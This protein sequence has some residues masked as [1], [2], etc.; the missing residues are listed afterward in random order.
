MKKEKGETNKETNK[1]TFILRGEN[2]T[3]E[4]PYLKQLSSVMLITM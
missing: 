2:V 1:K 4:R 3:I